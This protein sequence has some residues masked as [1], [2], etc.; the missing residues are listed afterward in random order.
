VL[1]NAATRAELDAGLAAGAEGVGLLRTELAFLE[2]AEWPTEQQHRAALAPVL[3]G[4]AGRTA[5]V[6]VLD[7]GA[8]KTPPFLAGTRERG[9]ELL[10]ARPEALAAQLRAI[11]DGGRETE[12]RVL[13]PMVE[14]AAQ[15]E[16]VR[17]VLPGAVALGAMIET[18]AAVAAAPAIAAAADFLSIGTNDLS[19]AVL[20]SDR[21]GGTAAAAHD[22][23]V[24]AAIAATA[25]AAAGARVVLEVCGEAASE[26]A[27]VPLLVG[28]GAGELSVG[29]ARVGAVR[30]WIRSLA[31]DEARRAA[32]AALAAGSGD[33]AAALGAALLLQ[34]RDAAGERVE[35]DGRVVAVGPEA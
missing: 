4:L 30:G 17:A 32:Q 6:R 12:L 7:F 28:L 24:L 20:G 15:V 33:E 27:S 25:R 10:L 26:P 18:R 5:T 3:S 29:A 23:R 8:D 14:S 21:F 1:V 22:P 31:R 11:V 34:R 16:A 2:A 35:R 19:H 13:L 9:L